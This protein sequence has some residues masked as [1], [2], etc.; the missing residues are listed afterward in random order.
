MHISLSKPSND[1]CMLWTICP[2]PKFYA[3]Y[4]STTKNNTIK[5]RAVMPKTQIC[6]KL[7]VIIFGRESH[8]FFTFC[9]ECEC[10]PRICPLRQNIWGYVSVM[11]FEVMNKTHKFC[12][13]MYIQ[14]IL[15]CNTSSR[16]VIYYLSFKK[17]TI[18]RC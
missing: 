4:L 17:T 6:K 3:L 5:L 11:Y 15:L 10:E 18:F 2:E 1:Y 16:I 7:L 13:F 9:V 12:F 8:F 14:L